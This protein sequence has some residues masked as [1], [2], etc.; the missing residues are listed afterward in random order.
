MLRLVF[1]PKPFSHPFAYRSYTT[2]KSN[3]PPHDRIRSDLQ[4]KT[5]TFRPSL[6]KPI[7][8]SHLRRKPLSP[9]TYQV[10]SSEPLKSQPCKGSQR[11]RQIPMDR[12]Q[13]HLGSPQKPPSPS[14]QRPEVRN[15]ESN[16]IPAT[17]QKIRNPQSAIRNH[18]GRQDNPG[19]PLKFRQNN[20][21]RTQEV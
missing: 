9:R 17:R 14:N 12:P 6:P 19:C 3:G 4:Q 7:Q 11:I 13:H 2:Q 20:E 18:I 10:H 15:E 5:Q 21:N 1:D 16:T 8:I